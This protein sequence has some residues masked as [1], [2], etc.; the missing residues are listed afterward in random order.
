MEWLRSF[1]EKH[2]CQACTTQPI[3]IFIDA[4]DECVIEARE[5]VANFLTD[6][7][8]GSTGACLK[9]FVSCRRHP[10]LFTKGSK[11]NMESNNKKD[12]ATFVKSRLQALPDWKRSIASQIIENARGSFQW[13]GIVTNKAISLHQAGRTVNQIREMINIIP[14][15][16]SELYDSLLR[17]L[18]NDD[19]QP[20]HRL[21]LWVCFARELLTIRHLQYAL[22][23]SLNMKEKCIKGICQR[24]DFRTE[25]PD[26]V[27]M[28]VYLSRG[29]IEIFPRRKQI[30]G[31]FS[32]SDSDAPLQH[33]WYSGVQFIHQTVVDYLLQTGLPWLEQNQQIRTEASGGHYHH[34]IA[35]SCRRL[36]EMDDYTTP[37][38]LLNKLNFM[39]SDAGYLGRCIERHLEYH[40]SKFE[41]EEVDMVEL[42]RLLGWPH[43]K[44]RLAYIPM[45][46]GKGFKDGQKFIFWEEFLEPPLKC[47]TNSLTLRN[48]SYLYHPSLL[49]F[50]SGMGFAKPVKSMVENKLSE[51]NDA[52]L[53]DGSFDATLPHP[54]GN[55]KLQRLLVDGYYNPNL[56]AIPTAETA[57]HL[58]VV[59]SRIPVFLKL[60]KSPLIDPNI[61]DCRGLT[62]PHLTQTVFH[63]EKVRQRMVE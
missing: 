28:I 7:I 2:I 50:L 18:N 3:F 29:L 6:T 57:L 19:K 52:F 41:D 58:A 8:H 42:L 55:D 35:K 27:N 12:L 56:L 5:N 63:N 59:K 33:R 43:N 22:M 4:L 45:P 47:Q 24:T 25:L 54:D 62:P 14:K 51:L 44:S 61:Q 15:D 39:R 17:D 16:I 34:F 38:G 30:F 31:R 11:V 53:L 49:H 60:L 9:I 37:T 1:L 48:D 32:R 40:V 10:Y 13:A 21:F 20:A 26:M 46:W 23:L 36:V